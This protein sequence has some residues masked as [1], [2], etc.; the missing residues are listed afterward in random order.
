MDKYA[1]DREEVASDGNI[2][3]ELEFAVKNLIAAEER[4]QEAEAESKRCNAIVN[5]LKFNTLPAIFARM[6][7]TDEIVVNV[8][9][10]RIPVIYEEKMAARL[11]ESK[12]ELVFAFLRNNGYENLINNNV[13]IPFTKGQSA[14]MNAFIEYVKNF[15]DG[16]LTIG[17]KE[18]V[19]PSTYTAWCD[20]NLKDNPGIDL[21][22]FGAHIVKQVKLGKPKTSKR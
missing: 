22:D 7:G 3:A 20:A 6:N 21:A 4:A 12:K 16:S 14:E 10:Q 18:E 9:G 1:G 17:Q 5:G 2:I 13:V 8:G 15:H 11:S 19:A